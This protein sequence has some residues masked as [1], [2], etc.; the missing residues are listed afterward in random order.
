MLGKGLKA[1]QM[2]GEG[3]GM[4]KSEGAVFYVALKG[5]RLMLL[6]RLLVCVEFCD[7]P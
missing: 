4:R 3:E 7:C 1:A 5:Q 6:V 2:V